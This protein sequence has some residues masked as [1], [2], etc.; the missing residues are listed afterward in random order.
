[1][2]FSFIDRTWDDMFSVAL[3]DDGVNIKANNWNSG[4]IGSKPLLHS[5]LWKSKERFAAG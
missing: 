4:E 3:I 2:A 1:M 5:T